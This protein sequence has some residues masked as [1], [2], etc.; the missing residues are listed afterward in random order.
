MRKLVAPHIGY[1][2]CI[3]CLKKIRRNALGAKPTDNSL[4]LSGKDGQ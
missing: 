2:S 3:C 4:L 1:L